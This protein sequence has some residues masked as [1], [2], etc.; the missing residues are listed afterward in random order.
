MRRGVSLLEVVFAIL[1]VSIGLLAALTV[2]PVASAIAKK[3]QNADVVAVH[4]KSAIH[5]F[6]TRGMRSPLNWMSWNQVAGAYQPYAPV[7]GEP[8]CLD[9]RGIGANITSPPAVQL[10]NS[11][12]PYSAAVTQPRMR[13][14]TLNSLGAPMSKA[15][16]DSIFTF[17][18]DLTMVR[19]ADGSLPGFGMLEQG[20]SNNDGNPDFYTK[21][22]S[23][24][25]FSWMATLAPKLEL[26]AG[27]GAIQNTDFVM[28]IV[29]F[30][31]RPGDMTAGDP[32]HERV[33]N[34]NFVDAG[35]LGFAGGEVYLTWDVP[36]SA[37]ND[38]LAPDVLK[39]RGGDWLMLAGFTQHTAGGE[40]SVCK[41][42]RVMEAD[43][44]PEYHGAPENH[45]AI[46]A[47]LG[48]SDWDTSLYGQSGAPGTP[49]IAVLMTGVLAVYEKTIRL[50]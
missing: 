48:G 50:E 27:P 12:F 17:A 44:E 40:A 1:V 11:V 4:G 32:L 45:Y 7:F 33:V 41:W 5:D 2:F 23:Q 37:A 46:A 39:V 49:P 36:Q 6:D 13:R 35:G 9:P 15:L 24:G 38:V 8:Y 3:G 42:Y 47:S 31:D 43:R 28:S 16:A 19:P 29:I 26:Y 22:S 20:D 21:R 30:N 10:T 18:D 25:H 34:A 14:L